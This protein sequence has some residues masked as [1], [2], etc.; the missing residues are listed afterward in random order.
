MGVN[1]EELDYQ[2]TALGELILRRRQALAL[3]G[4]EIF[5]V[6][7]ND[8]FLMSSLFHDGEVA[9]TDLGL[10]ELTG[11]GWDIV[12]G[13]LGL[14]YTAAAALKYDQ[15]ARMIVVEAL[16][17]V[18]EWH[19]RELVPNGT[20]LSKDARCRYYH[21]DFFALARGDGFD[22]DDSGHQFDAILLD[23]DHTPD[24]LLNSRHADLYSEEGMMRLRAFLRPEGVFGLWSNDVPDEGF[25]AILS[26]VFSQVDGHVV[27]FE[28]PIQGKTAANGV[29]VAK[30]GN[31][32]L[33]S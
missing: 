21:A 20:L 4:R 23:I 17:P 16:A 12:V 28:N 18:I 29:Y 24:A 15:V 25:L 3:G 13:G 10:A 27:E 31:G 30:V 14:G 33:S 2:Q 22:P 8:E 19:Q 26:R 11:Q 9:L 32:P 6:K 1:F 5:E 7:L